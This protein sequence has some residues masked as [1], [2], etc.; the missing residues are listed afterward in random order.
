MTK[1][2]TVH[3]EEVYSRAMNR[4]FIDYD[5]KASISAVSRLIEYQEAHFTVGI[6]VGGH[7]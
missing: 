6:A 5:E 7:W 2:M 3:S 1:I 4:K